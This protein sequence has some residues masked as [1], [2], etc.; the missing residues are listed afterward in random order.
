M[1]SSVV[2]YVRVSTD[3][4]AESGAGLRAQRDAI[5]A[6]VRRR[7]WTLSTV[8]EDAGASAKSMDR[9]GL[10]AALRAVESGEASGLVVAKLDRLSRSLLDFASLMARSKKKG[11]SLIALDL[12]VDTTTP[13]G[14]MMANI[15]ATFAQFERDLIGQRTKDALAV[16]RSQGVKLGR[17]EGVS[18]RVADRIRELHKSGLSLNAIATRLT[19]DAVPTAQGGRRWYASTVRAIVRAADDAV[20]S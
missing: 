10:K 2:G 13:A 1:V 4:Q 3:G 9:P 5:A 12:G 7:G 6:E 8:Y 11:W 16:K 19:A 15:L 14:A 18:A 17:F 20:R